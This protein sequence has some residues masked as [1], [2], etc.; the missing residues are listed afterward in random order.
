MFDANS[1][2]DITCEQDLRSGVDYDPDSDRYKYRYRCTGPRGK[3][4]YP[5]RLFH[6]LSYSNWL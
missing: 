4:I 5:D 2:A 3:A 6:F 1:N